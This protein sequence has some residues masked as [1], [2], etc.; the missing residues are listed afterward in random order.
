[1]RPLMRI[2][3]T[4]TSPGTRTERTSARWWVFRALSGRFAGPGRAADGHGG[5]TPF[6]LSS[7]RVGPR[8]GPTRRR[9]TSAVLDIAKPATRSCVPLSV[10]MMRNLPESP[11]SSESSESP[12]FERRAPRDAVPARP[13]LFFCSAAQSSRAAAGTA[14]DSAA[15]FSAKARPGSPCPTS[16]TSAFPFSATS[17]RRDPRP[18]RRDL[19]RREHAPAPPPCRRCTR[20]D[21]A[22]GSRRRPAWSAS[23]SASGRAATGLRPVR[24]RGLVREL[25]EATSA[26]SRRAHHRTVPS[27][28]S[29]R[30]IHARSRNSTAIGGSRCPASTCSSPPPSGGSR[31]SPRSSCGTGTPRT[32]A[33]SRV[34]RAPG[35]RET[36]STGRRERVPACA[37]RRRAF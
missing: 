29:P 24:L 32:R 21:G 26:R 31:G 3:T 23:R 34:W 37:R 11:E 17:N 12:R 14:S 6:F 4:H 8:V 10:F 13:R 30:A 33:C 9:T 7:V 1:M 36:R 28:V 27:P 22:P 20:A 25:V 18:P 15:A 35:T 19:A 2:R 16:R 5:E